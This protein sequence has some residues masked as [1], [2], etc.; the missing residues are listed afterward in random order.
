MSHKSISIALLCCILRVSVTDASNAP[1]QPKPDILFIAVDDLNDWTSYLG[2]HPQA[3]TPNID[4]LVAKGTAF[5][6]S[7]CAAPACNPSRAAL[8]GGKRPWQTG[9]YTNGDPAAGVLRDTNTLNRH[10]IE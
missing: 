8:L 2:G 9:I 6:N 7:H 4:R 10:L 3:R 1:K 5:T